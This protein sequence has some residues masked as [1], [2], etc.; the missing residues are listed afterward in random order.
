MGYLEC[1]VQIHFVVSER[2]LSSSSDGWHEMLLD[3][4]IIFVYPGLGTL[5]ARTYL[6]C[7]P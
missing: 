4:C 7:G 1:S 2:K 3:V 6:D 5:A